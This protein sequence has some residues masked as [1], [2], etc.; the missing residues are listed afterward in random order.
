MKAEKESKEDELMVQKESK[1]EITTGSK[2]IAGYLPRNIRDQAQMKE[3]LCG[4]GISESLQVE[5]MLPLLHN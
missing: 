4:I 2:I 3:F 1:E 5:K